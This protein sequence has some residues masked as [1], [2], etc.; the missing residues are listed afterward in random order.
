M[1]IADNAAPETTVQ[2]NT[3][4]TTMEALQKRLEEEHVTARP[5]GW[6]ENCLVL[7]G[8]GSIE[9]LPSFREGLFYV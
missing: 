1:L 3:L 2:V 6:M 5:H 9:N 7:S 8:T 4:R